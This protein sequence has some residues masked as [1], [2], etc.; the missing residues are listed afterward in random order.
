MQTLRHAE[1][2]DLTDVTIDDEFWNSRL[3]RNR[4]VTLEY[5]Y[6]HLKTSDCL[7][8]FR[9][10]A[11]APDGRADDRGGFQGIWFAD[12]DAYK[13]LEAASYV[14]ATHDDSGLRERVD[15]VI[16]LVAAAQDDTGYLNTYFVL[17]EPEKRWTNLNMMHELYCAGHLVEAAV[18]HHRA[19]G[20][21]DLLEANTEY[22]PELD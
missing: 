5:Q 7:E 22:L 1:S 13:W 12:S 14:L 21:R 15:E 4:E 17:E 19:T 8:N 3:E 11:A 18:A 6:D 9:R 2:V 10:A 16:D 20:E